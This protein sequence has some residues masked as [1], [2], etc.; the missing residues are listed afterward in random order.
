MLDSRPGPV[1]GAGGSSES[2]APVRL[3]ES[4]GKHG[5][6]S[7]GLAAVEP[8]PSGAC[9]LSVEGQVQRRPAEVGLVLSMRWPVSSTVLPLRCQPSVGAPRLNQTPNWPTQPK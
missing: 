9:D 6:L 7:T 1:V 3:P 4:R 2:S 5:A 8:A